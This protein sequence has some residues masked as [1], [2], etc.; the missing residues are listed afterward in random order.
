[1]QI[2]IRPTDFC[3]PTNLSTCTRARGSRPISR[4]RG[5]SPVARWIEGHDVSRRRRPLPPDRTLRPRVF[6]GVASCNQASD[7]PV[8][9]SWGRAALADDCASGRSSQDRRHPSSV[10]RRGEG[11]IRCA[12][13]RQDARATERLVDPDPGLA[14]WMLPVNV[15]G[16][17]RPTDRFVV[18]SARASTL[19]CRPRGSPSTEPPPARLLPDREGRCRA[20]G[21]S[22]FS[23]VTRSFKRASLG[24]R[25]PTDLCNAF[26]RA[27]TPASRESSS[28]RGSRLGPR[29]P[30]P[31]GCPL[32]RDLPVVTHRHDR[33]RSRPLTAC[34]A[35]IA[36]DGLHHRASIPG[37]TPPR[38]PAT[39]VPIRREFCPSGATAET[40][41]VR[42]ER[43]PGFYAGS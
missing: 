1:M 41:I 8:A 18:E 22:P 19:R 13:L 17:V 14:T 24:L 4:L 5:M 12:F 7:T 16:V 28:A 21:C 32:A 23:E 31:G 10:K 9:R 37:S 30:S 43:D 29:L 38:S 39:D 34:A 27:G 42:H 40:A 20:P 26:R 25:L 3:H 15:H 2:R 6:T 35:C 33:C 36:P 11:T